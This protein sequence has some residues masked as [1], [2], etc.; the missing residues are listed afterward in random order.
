MELPQSSP[1]IRSMTETLMNSSISNRDFTDALSFNANLQKELCNRENPSLIEVIEIC[2][3]NFSLISAI[4][5]QTASLEWAISDIDPNTIS[6][7]DYIINGHSTFVIAIVGLISNIIGIVFVS[8]GDRKG[9]FF[10]LLLAAMFTSNTLFALFTILRCIDSFFLAIPASHLHTFT[11]VV[12]SGIRFSTTSSVFF[13]VA[14]AHARLEVI[15][16]PLLNQ[17]RNISSHKTRIMFLKYLVPILFLSTIMTLPI[18]WETEEDTSHML[19]GTTVI[20]PSAFRSSP[21]YSIFF[22]GFLNLGLLGMFPL[23]TLS[24]FN[25]HIIKE[26]RENRRRISNFN[27]NILINGRARD[28]EQK[29]LTQCLI[30]IIFIFIILH[31]ILHIFNVIGELMIMAIQNK[32]IMGGKNFFVFPTFYYFTCSISEFFMIV[33][34]TINV[35]IYLFPHLLKICV[36][37]LRDNTLLNNVESSEQNRNSNNI[38]TINEMSHGA[39]RVS[40]GMVD[41]LEPN[42]IQEQEGAAASFAYN[43]VCPDVNCK[44]CVIPSVEVLI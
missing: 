22:T 18:Y 31:G 10:N 41:H 30:F 13:L 29:I 6:T 11:T 40:L 43:A 23:I 14:I 16:K 2:Q 8:S 12:N 36:G 3:H 28:V 32:D 27:I 42:H 4:F 1:S 19:G 38:S 5:N 15:R 25:F 24:Y 37:F 39:A 33:Y 17:T 44:F 21:I 9:K 7:F 26:L 20:V 35:M 34:A